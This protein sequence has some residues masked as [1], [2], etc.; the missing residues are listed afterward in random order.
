MKI[1]LA[2]TY[3]DVHTGLLS[4]LLQLSFQLKMPLILHLTYKMHPTFSL[5]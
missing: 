5:S 4:Y 3:F 1:G 2:M